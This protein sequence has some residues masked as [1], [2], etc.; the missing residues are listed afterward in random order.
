MI[1]INSYNKFGTKVQILERNETGFGLLIEQDA[2]YISKSLN[3]DFI[4][5]GF[6][7]DELDPNKP[8]LINCILQKW[9]VENRN[10]R[11]YPKEVLVPQVDLY[12]TQVAD[13]VAISEVNHPSCVSASESMICTKD[14]WKHFENI[15]E[16]EEI[17]TLNVDTNQIEIHKI[18]KKIY[19]DYNGV[20]YNFRARNIELTITPNHKF[21]LEHSVTKKRS[22]WFAEDIYNNKD[23]VL[24]CKKYKILKSGEWIGEYNEYFT[25]DGVDRSYLGKNCSHDLVD[26]YT[27]PISIKSEDWFAFLGFYLAEGHATGTKSNK[28][29]LNGYSVVI[30]QKKKE[31]CEKF[32]T[33]LT[34]MPFE[35]KVYVSDDDCYKYHINDARLY[36]YLFP[37]GMS[38]DKYIPIEI[39]QASSDLLKIFFDWFMLGDGRSLIAKGRSKN[40]IKSVFST[41]EKLIE[42]LH[43]VLI[44]IGGSG[45][46]TT[47]QPIDR[48]IN[49]KK[50]TKRKVTN[51]D[52]TI[53][54]IKDFEIVRREIKAENSH[55]QYNLNI[56]HAKHTYL[57]SRFTK[58][59]KI[60]FNNK[61]ACV[62]VK[63]NNFLVKVNGKSHWTGNS[64]VLDLKNIS[65]AIRKMWWGTGD[66]E[67]VLFGQL[68]LIVSPGFI[69]LGIVSAP[70]DMIMLLLMH[71]IKIG[72]SSRGVGSL[73][74]IQ[75]KNIV[76]NDF[77]LV[78]FDLVSTPSTFGAY[79][80]PDK[81]E[82]NIGETTNK[83]ETYNK[84]ENTEN[85][86]NKKLSALNKFLGK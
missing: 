38:H 39:K 12:Q 67:N 16:D 47:Y 11:I 68:E 9:G 37:L 7:F 65:H 13:N 76:Q 5:E 30:S 24:T 61:I 18:D 1:D 79:L 10:G 86:Y 3:A 20:M 29:F 82:L 74:Q 53:D 69:K 32:E 70:G 59:E 83:Q 23:S 26:K 60:D 51:E 17:L 35:F 57:D 85:S 21:L 58:I 49:E 31:V 56:S 45:N 78:G 25:L 84:P 15:S 77:E 8:I 73:K 81:N 36:K 22:F 6:A 42:D 43:E 40:G 72:I 54:I 44:K 52:G 27:Q 34:K 75:G 41:S 62:S 28:E 55:I 66:N 48:C 2:G 80:F 33:I 63:N 46:I 64:S 4:N 14:G 50:Y 19:E 71:N